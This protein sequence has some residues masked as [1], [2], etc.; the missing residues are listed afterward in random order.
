MR[1][2]TSRPELTPIASLPLLYNPR[3]LALIR[4]TVALDTTDDEFALFIHWAR[5]L[6]LD[7]LRRQVHA[8]VFNKQD[9]KKRRLS[10]VTSIEGLRAVAA[11]TSNYR[12]DE[13][14]PSF[15][16]DDARKAET[17]PA[18]LV[19]SSVR[20]WQHSHGQWF[21]VTGLAHWDEF[22]PLKTVWV[23]NQPTERKVLDKSAAGATCPF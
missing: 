10:L 11:R 2:T 15:I 20:V 8:F 5:S 16:C 7:P 17:N 22:A 19:S 6:R 18:G 9:P 3:D 4:R 21:P 13:N 23:D 12:P 14:E 1:P